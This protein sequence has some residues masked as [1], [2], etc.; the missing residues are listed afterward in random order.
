MTTFKTISSR[1]LEMTSGGA[2]P[3]ATPLPPEQ[4]AL[5]AS[6]VR[7]LNAD[8]TFKAQGPW[9][10][11]AAHHQ[12]LKLDRFGSAN[13][14]VFANNGDH[15]AQVEMNKSAGTAIRRLP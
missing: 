15:T 13:P 14:I 4:E 8:P 12:G 1:A 5:I 2:G 10:A 6:G 9:S 11:G 7:F 3:M